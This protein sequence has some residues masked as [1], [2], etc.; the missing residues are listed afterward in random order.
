MLH[1][2]RRNGGGDG[3]SIEPENGSVLAS[4]IL[5][6]FLKRLRGPQ[7]PRLLD[8]GRLSGV[9][10]EFFA[11]RGCTVQVEDL[12]LATERAAPDGGA[13]AAPA[14]ADDRETESG[15]LLATDAPAAG[16]PAVQAAA[17]PSPTLETAAGPVAPVAPDRRAPAAASPGVAATP[18]TR[19]SRRIVLPPRTFQRPAPPLGRTPQ[20]ER[21]AAATRA[22]AAQ[23]AALPDRFAYADETFDAVVAWEIFNFYDAAAMS[24]IAADA[25]RILKPGGL[26]LA[27]FHARR[28]QGPEIARR[29]RI[30]D[31]THIACETDRGPHLN[32]FVYQNRDIEK[33]FAGLTIVE[34][35]FLKSATREILMEKKAARFR[36]R[37]LIGAAA[38]KPRFTIE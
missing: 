33:M 5:A 26:L 16:T 8:L 38:A 18:G 1:L 17:S 2:F 35:F 37:T 14:P 20:A 4:H 3:A 15:M 19:P 25:H 24:R 9:N 23:N 13:A 27:F 30:L 7:R 31:E 12:L 10:I 29:Y 36:P 28:P 6:R 11:N 22:S 34:A 21:P 32:R